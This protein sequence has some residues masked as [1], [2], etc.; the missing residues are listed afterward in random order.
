MRRRT[1][2]PSM[3]APRRLRPKSSNRRTAITIA[4]VIPAAGNI[5]GFWFGTRNAITGQ[6]AMSSQ[7]SNRS[8]G[9]SANE[10][11][12][13]PAAIIPPNCKPA[14][15]P[16]VPAASPSMLTDSV[17]PASRDGYQSGLG[18]TP[19][20][21]SHSSAKPQV[22]V[23]RIGVGWRTQ[24]GEAQAENRQRHNDHG[25]PDPARAPATAG[26]P[27]CRTTA[28]I[29]ARCLTIANAPTAPRPHP[30]GRKTASGVSFAS[31]S[32]CRTPAAIA[33]TAT[34]PAA[35][36]SAS[37]LSPRSRIARRQPR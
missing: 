33:A 29:R 7:A 18:M 25:A 8:R 21:R 6:L 24:S 36:S 10:R 31:A 20:C 16:S 14:P 22:V 32:P 3:R 17:M 4:M 27:R 1:Q 37:A 19:P 12:A 34:N 13:T 2:P 11:S 26:R 9:V 35:K 30:M 15:R 23:Q 5:C 28:T